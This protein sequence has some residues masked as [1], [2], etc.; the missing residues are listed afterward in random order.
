M[1]AYQKRPLAGAKQILTRDE[2]GN[3]LDTA[4]A[5]LK[6]RLK[7]LDDLIESRQAQLANLPD[8]AKAE[9]EKR[10]TEI[11]KLVADIDQIKTDLVNQAKTRSE[12]EQGGIAAILIRNTEA[13]EIAK[14]MLE[15]RQKNTSVSFDGIKARNIVTLG[16]LGEN[17]QYAKNDLNRVPF[18]PLSL[19]DLI[20]WAPLTNDI[21][22][23]LRETAW[24]LMADIVPEGE[25]KPESSLEF[26]PLVLN[27]GVIAHWIKVSNQVLADMPML[28]SYI[29]SRLAY[30]IRYKLEYFVVNGH[31][32]AAGQPKNF[33][34]LMEAG[35]HVTVT[36]EAGDTALDV[37]NRAKYKAALSFLQ[38]ECYVLNPQDWGVI[39]RLKGS[40]GHYL[41]G[42]PTGTG[43]QAFLWGL[44]VRFSPVQKPAKFWCGNLSIGF[45]GY[46][47]EDV[48]TQVSLE[49][50]DN[51][52]KNLATV[53]SEMR[54]AGGVIIPDANVAGDLPNVPADRVAPAL[55]VVLV[56]SA[57]ELSGT[58]EASAVIK[59]RA[60]KGGL[61]GITYADN[62]GAWSI[63]PNPLAVGEVGSV[64]ATDEADNTS[65]ALSV[66]GEA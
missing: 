33:S 36:V 51:F 44:P 66:T 54:A 57:K 6:K 19:V 12:D 34:G 38:P 39:E 2:N 64:T 18:Q 35:N 10:A 4:S 14:T 60:A 21:V 3:P 9:L 47:R 31:I 62:A 45:D 65:Q 41:I 43:V 48:D 25:E 61:I 1:T 22:T 15:K 59:V 56:N 63:K 32:P 13:L 24:D 58:A 8:D 29:E 49:D 30:G 28:A 26:G 55:P 42:V 46:I 5:E 17:Y 50:G 11:N 20:N 7:Q 27:V 37:L 52:R 16:S 23:L 53:R 40:D